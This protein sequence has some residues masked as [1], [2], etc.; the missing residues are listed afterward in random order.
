M[1]T[2]THENKFTGP[3]TYQISVQ[4]NIVNN[5]INR[6]GEMEVSKTGLANKTISTLTGNVQDQS[7]LSG[8]LNTLF[9]YRYTVISVLKLN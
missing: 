2:T 8:I 7:A 6:L 9:D 4:G 1:N 5:L 3:A